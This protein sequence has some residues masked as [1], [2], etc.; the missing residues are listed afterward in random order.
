MILSIIVVSY[1]NDHLLSRCLNSMVDLLQNRKIEIIVIDDG[2]KINQLDYIPNEFACCPNFK[3]I[4]Q[5]N[6]GLGGARNTGINNA[7]GNY[8][9]FVDGDDYFIQDKFSIFYDKYSEVFMNS[10]IDLIKWGMLIN[11]ENKIRISCPKYKF[12]KN[13]NEYIKYTYFLN[14]YLWSSCTFIIRRELLIKNNIYFVERSFSEDFDFMCKLNP[15]IKNCILTNDVVYYYDNNNQMSIT[16]YKKEQNL[17]DFSL[18]FK[19]HFSESNFLFR[20]FLVIY[21]LSN[22][23]RWKLL[24]LR[25]VIWY[26]LFLPLLL[27]FN[28]GPLN[29]I[30]FFKFV[31]KKIIK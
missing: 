9:L 11:R 24:E 26:L 13:N 29:F 23:N 6:K 21:W 4:R 3:I 19:K 27:F 16:N 12:C 5:K 8:I 18:F 22:K 7:T 2:S 25:K 14:E 28:L 15:F 31:F 1:N 20:L 17:N 10:N 30:N